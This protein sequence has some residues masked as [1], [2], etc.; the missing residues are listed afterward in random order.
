MTTIFFDCFCSFNSASHGSMITLNNRLDEQNMRSSL[1][2][3]HGLIKTGRKRK[4]AGKTSECNPS[5]DDSHVVCYL[6]F[7]CAGKT[8]EGESC[9]FVSFIRSTHRRSRGSN[10]RWWEWWYKSCWW[11]SPIHLTPAPGVDLGVAKVQFIFWSG[12]IELLFCASVL[13]KIIII[14]IIMILIELL[15][16]L[17]NNDNKR[18]RGERENKKLRKIFEERWTSQRSNNCLKS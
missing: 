10:W 11:W 1:I 12:K 16:L 8:R 6:L 14:I 18:I 7:G 3:Q 4:G 17:C 5:Q 9:A 2:I 13:C 15:Y